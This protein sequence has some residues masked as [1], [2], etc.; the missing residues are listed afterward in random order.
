[1]AEKTQSNR[2]RCL[3]TGCNPLLFGVDQANAHADSEDHRVAKWPVRSEAGKRKARARNKSGY[4][5]KYNV[6]EKSYDVRAHLF[7]P[8]YSGV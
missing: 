1:M 8:E 2:W 6:G 7:D 5:D 4:Y 3:K